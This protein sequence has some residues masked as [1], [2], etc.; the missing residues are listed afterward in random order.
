MASVFASSRLS[1][2]ISGPSNISIKHGQQPVDV[3]AL[4][5]ASRVLHDQ[6]AKD[7]QIIPDLG[8]MLAA[9]TKN[10]LYVLLSS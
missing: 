2:T 4:Q 8:E 7:A 9:S 5:N 3:H 1:G 10:F 6:F